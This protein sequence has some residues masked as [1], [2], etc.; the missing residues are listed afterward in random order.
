MAEKKKQGRPKGTTKPD[1]KIQISG[2]RL[3]KEAVKAL[4]YFQQFHKETYVETVEV[5]VIERMKRAQR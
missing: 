4:M 3:K 2:M 5:A 1:S